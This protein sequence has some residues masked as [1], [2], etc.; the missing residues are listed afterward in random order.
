MYTCTRVHSTYIYTA[1]TYGLEWN[2]LLRASL[3]NPILST[4][5]AE[6]YVVP[7]SLHPQTCMILGRPGKP[8]QTWTATRARA[9]VRVD[10]Q[11]VFNMC[12]LYTPLCSGGAQEN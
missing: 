10:I 8:Q 3:M 7:V 1:Y 4:G 12:H 6:C 5:T 11:Y 2:G 9:S